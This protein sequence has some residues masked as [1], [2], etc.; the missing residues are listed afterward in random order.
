MEKI[1]VN[2]TNVFIDLI[3]AG[4]LD[5]FFR[6]PWEVH[7][8]DSVMLEVKREGEREA[9]E[10]YIRSG[11]LKVGNFSPKEVIKILDLLSSQRGKSNVSFTD[12]S[13]WFYARTH[14]CSLLTGDWKLRKQAIND[15][16]DVHGIIYVFDKLVERA[17]I[18]ADIAVERLKILKSNNPRLPMDEINK[19]ILEWSKLK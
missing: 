19:R 8:T 18:G 3:D 9:V 10:E 17:I 15:G 1:V 2:D 16:I 5:E 13:V 12:C 11:F 14:K 6:L 7:T 4:L